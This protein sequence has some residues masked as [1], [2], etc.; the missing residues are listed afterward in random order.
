MRGAKNAKVEVKYLRQGKTN[1]ATIV[2]DEVEV[3]AVP[4][5]G[6]VDEK[7]GYI[8]LSQFNR[9]ATSETQAALKS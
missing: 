2:L 6:K 7:T 3:K 1:T 4:F 8:V 9:K 5:F